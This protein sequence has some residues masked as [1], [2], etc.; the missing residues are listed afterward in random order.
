VLLDRSSVLS[1]PCYDTAQGG[2]VG[3]HTY[4]SLDGALDLAARDASTGVCPCS[5]VRPGGRAALGA[6]RPCK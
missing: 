2:G 1:V 5:A 3:G 4:C 6:V